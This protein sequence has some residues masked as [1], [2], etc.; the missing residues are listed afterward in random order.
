MTWLH[1]EKYDFEQKQTKE[2]KEKVDIVRYR[3]TWLVAVFCTSFPSLPSVQFLPR[4]HDSMHFD[5]R[6]DRLTAQSVG[7]GKPWM[8]DMAPFRTVRF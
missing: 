6:P 4:P 3:R 1:F 2:T 8:H 7:L 5:R